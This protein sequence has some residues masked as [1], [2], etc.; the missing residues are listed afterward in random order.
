MTATVSL[1]SIPHRPPFLFVDQV[2]E[3]ANQRIVA[4]KFV[5]P[6]ADFFR[7]HYPGHPVMPGVL[8]CECIFQ[9]GALLIASRNGGYPSPAGIPV[10]ARISDARFRRIVRPGDAL[11][12][13]VTLDEEL[14]GAFFMTG[15]AS[16]A[17]RLVVRVGFSAMLVPD[18][19]DNP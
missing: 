16:V 10:L 9:T 11:R 6:Q 19:G 12:M 8:V 1:H 18:R 5:D 2:V 4:T 3:V 13:E 15:R 14:E 7:G 17:D